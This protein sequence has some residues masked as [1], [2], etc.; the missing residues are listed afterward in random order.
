MRYQETQEL[1]TAQRALV[2]E[3]YERLALWRDACS[4]YHKKAKESR[5]ILALDDPLQDAPGAAIKTLQLHTL[6]STFNGCVADQIDNMPEAVMIPERPDVA[7]TAEELTDVTRWV[8]GHN[9]YEALHRKRVEDCFCT[10]TSVTQVAW[11]PDMDY[12]E[13]NIAILRWPVEAFLWDPAAENLQDARAVFK[14]SWHPMSWYEQHYPEQYSSIGSDEGEYSTIGVSDVSNIQADEERAM[15]MEYWYRLFDAKKRRYTINVAYLAGGALLELSEDIY[16]HGRYP[17][18]MD[19]FSRIEGTPVGE[20]MIQELAP[21]MRYINRYAAYIDMNLRMSAKGRLLVNRNAGI[22][23]AVLADWEKDIIEADR[24]DT[25]ALQWLQS[26]PFTGMVSNQMMQLQ[27]DLKQDSGQNQFTR[28]E[29][30]GGVTAFGAI[31]ALQ[32]AGGKITRLRTFSLNDGFREICEQVMWLIS[33]FYDEKRVL[34]ITGMKTEQPREVVLDTKKIYGK[35]PSGKS[36]PPPPYTVQVQVQRRNPMRV[37]AQN[38][39]FMQMYTMAAQAQQYFPISVLLELLQVDGKEKILPVIRQNE[40][41]AQQMQEMAAQNEQ[42]AQ[43]NAQLQEGVGNLQA[44]N[45]KI[46]QTMR[47]EPA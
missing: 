47:K 27:T 19:V 11:D 42:L 38:D 1:N 21:M 43:E 15:L 32:E 40:S 39:L 35:K 37:Q 45:Q 4:G 36:L 41:Q 46:T 3:A 9:N 28:G 20:G 29:T 2:T 10:G 33:Q 18:K 8:F 31:N 17:F 6:K 14:V 30:T 26:Q 5:R 23:V 34:Y 16:Q 44:L 12:G 24:I 22:D 13:G 7:Q 25:A